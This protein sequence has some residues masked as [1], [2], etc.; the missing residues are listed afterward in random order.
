MLPF[1]VKTL[2]LLAI[3]TGEALE[4][5]MLTAPVAVALLAM[6]TEALEVAT[7]FSRFIDKPC[8]DTDGVFA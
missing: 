7:G 5:A 1:I 2:L 4:T 6:L 3:F 8:T